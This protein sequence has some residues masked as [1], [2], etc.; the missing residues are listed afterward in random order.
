MILQ[1][2]SKFITSAKLVKPCRRP[3]MH[4][5]SS[6]VTCRWVQVVTHA[7]HL[8]LHH[9]QPVCKIVP[10]FTCILATNSTLRSSDCIQS[11]SNFETSISYHRLSSLEE[12]N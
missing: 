2:P 6:I 1:M 11:F 7:R 3:F 8:W 9:H 5:V 10:L 12:M 4:C